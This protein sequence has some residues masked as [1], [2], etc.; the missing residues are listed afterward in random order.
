M[1]N[2]R[3]QFIFLNPLCRITEYFHTF[4]LGLRR[5]QPY[6][7][8]PIIVCFKNTLLICPHSSIA[9][10]LICSPLIYFEYP[11]PVADDVTQSNMSSYFEGKTDGRCVGMATLRTK[12]LHHEVLFWP[13]LQ[14]LLL[15]NE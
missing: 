8:Y 15:V 3:G 12:N 9:G 2:V 11:A 10:L 7:E 14:Y 13:F 6:F 4:P 5:G 1:Q